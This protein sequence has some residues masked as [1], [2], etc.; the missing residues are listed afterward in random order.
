MPIDRFREGSQIQLTRFNPVIGTNL[1]KGIHSFRNPGAT[2]GMLLLLLA[3]IDQQAL[4]WGSAILVAP[5][6]AL[7]A[8]HVY[9]SFKKEGLLDKEGYLHAVGPHENG[10]IMWAVTQVQHL[11]ISDLALL[12]LSPMGDMHIGRLDLSLPTIAVLAPNV[13]EKVFSF[14]FS[15]DSSHIEVSQNIIMGEVDFQ[16]SIGTVEEVYPIGRDRVMISWP[17]FMMRGRLSGGMSGGPIFN[18]DGF[19]IGINTSSNDSDDPWAIFSLLWP[20]VVEKFT[21]T[22]SPFYEEIQM[23]LMDIGR[24]KMAFIG[25]QDE[26][27]HRDPES[28]KLFINVQKICDPER[29]LERLRPDERTSALL[30][31]HSAL[32]TVNG[33]KEGEIIVLDVASIE[34]IPILIKHGVGNIQLIEGRDSLLIFGE[35]KKFRCKRRTEKSNELVWVEF[36][37]DDY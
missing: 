27:A 21:P 8:G 4:P 33:G 17:S 18:K 25:C 19:L 3:Q 16:V 13:G 22:K 26:W 2:Q 30:P 29:L 23:N 12:I 6:L 15:A 5:G 34:Q 32:Y 31:I 7:T 10:T 24:R 14:G 20:V 37:S 9:D 1:P 11:N 36:R 35:Q 28:G